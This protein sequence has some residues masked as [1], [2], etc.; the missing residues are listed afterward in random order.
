MEMLE[1]FMSLEFVT[2]GNWTGIIFWA[3]E[4]RSLEASSSG[5]EWLVHCRQ[6][7]SLL[8]TFSHR[9]LTVSSALQ[10]T[11]GGQLPGLVSG[12][13]PG[14][15][16]PIRIAIR[17]QQPRKRGRTLQPLHSVNYKRD[18]SIC[19]GSLVGRWRISTSYFT[20]TSHVQR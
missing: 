17:D 7:R 19:S 9:T 20:S 3:F 15:H 5:V 8:E 6:C 11:V 10:R 14:R 1:M 2:N 12:S 16:S 4:V 18:L 13:S